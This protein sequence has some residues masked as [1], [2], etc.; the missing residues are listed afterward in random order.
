MPCFR[1]LSK[2][3]C[4]SR[5]QVWYTTLFQGWVSHSSKY[6]PF[7]P[8][9]CF[10]LWNIGLTVLSFALSIEKISCH[11]LL[12]SMVSEEKFVIWI[13]SPLKAMHCFSLVAFKFFF[14]FFFSPFFF[15]FFCLN[16]QK[17]AYDV[18]LHW[19][20]WAYPVWNFLNFSI[21]DL[22]LSPN[23]E[24]FRPLFVWILF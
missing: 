7:S 8:E 15:F 2:K 19:F 6:K 12:A 3:S 23:L 18:I 10:Y 9:G 22:C 14:G 16:L 20:L 5:N 17:F 11:F 4:A 24:D 1:A 13:V 21:V